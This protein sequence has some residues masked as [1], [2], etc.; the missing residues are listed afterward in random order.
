MKRFS[1]KMLP[2]IAVLMLMTI[3]PAAAEEPATTEIYFQIP[4]NT[5]CSPYSPVELSFEIVN[6]SSRTADFTLHLYKE[7]GTELTN[8]G[9]SYDG[10]KSM[11]VPGSHTRLNGNA[12]GLFHYTFGST[13][14]CGDR[15]YSGKIAAEGKLRIIG[16]GWVNSKMGMMD[17]TV[18]G[19]ET[20]SFG[21]DIV[22][23]P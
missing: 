3:I 20:V 4:M 7:D 18:R 15:V 1:L 12:A 5:Y 13:M 17:F 19:D 10:I 21:R 9:S 6:A 22:P 2:F 11:I 14:N 16:R 23:K 8:P